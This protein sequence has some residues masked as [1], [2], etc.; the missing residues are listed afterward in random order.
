MMATP[1]KL[2]QPSHFDSF[3]CIGSACEDTCCGGWMIPVDK[4]TYGKYQACSDSQFDSSLQTL[5]QINQKSAG[6]DD[7]AHI[8]LIGATCP[9]LSEGLCSIQRRLGE[10]YL[11]NMCATYPRVMNRVDN[12]LHRSLDLSCPEAARVVLL[13]PKPISFDH[14]VY[15]EGSIRPGNIPSLDISGL[16]TYPEPYGSFRD[17]QRLVISL[18]QD[19]S[20]PLWQRLFRVGLLCRKL[21]ETGRARWDGDSPD[22]L[23]QPA[24]PKTQLETVLELIVARITSDANPRRFLECY[25]EFMDG[26]Q[27]TS[28]STMNEMGK[29]YTEAFHQYYAP[30]MTRNEHMLEHYLVTYV[31]RTL[32]P[33]GTPESNQRLRDKRVPSL[34][35]ARY[36]LMVAYYAITQTL[37][38][39]NA[40][41]HKSSFGV[42]H[43]LKTIQSCAKTF[44]HS[45]TY[46]A[47][48]IG[49]LAE[50]SM[51][52]PASL[53]VL[54]RPPSLAPVSQLGLAETVMVNR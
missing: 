18:L 45:M 11:S 30:F 8:A 9:F 17:I 15:R 46:P 7:Y 37:L 20:Y 3:R 1:A 54:F 40:G 42:E 10:E 52:A 26:I 33:F 43:V 19:R 5:V 23:Q 47:R 38:A 44:E 41:F 35:A 36:M 51:T 14:G 12:V 53:C 28:K 4:A 39:G 34:T 29:R 6:D 22:V 32:F 25:K 50:K 13:N 16:K 24:D 48:A 2:F 27:W 21:D 31:H 49:M